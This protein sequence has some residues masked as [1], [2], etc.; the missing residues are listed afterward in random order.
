MAIE[1]PI[2][3]NKIDG[4]F[5]CMSNFSAHGIT[6]DGLVYR[7]SEHFF[8]AMKF[9]TTPAI[10]E[11]IRNTKSPMSAAMAGRSRSRPLRRDWEAIKDVVMEAALLCKFSQHVEL[12]GLLLS[13]HDRRLVEHTARDKYWGDGGDRGS[14]TIGKN[15]L[16]FL[17][18]KVR[19]YFASTEGSTPEQVRDKIESLMMRIRPA[20][21]PAG[22]V[23][24]IALGSASS[25]KRARV[26]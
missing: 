3:F 15:R 19:A 9:A 17:L 11:E 4:P 5:G 26:E 21:V 6:V 22:G 24:G 23:Q 13:T 2:L 12:R 7:T 18:E 1:A 8:Q 14:G 25:N 20:T 16:G 10:A